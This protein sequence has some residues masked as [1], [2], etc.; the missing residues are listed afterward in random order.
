MYFP[1]THWSLLAKATLD[2]EAAGCAALEELCRRYWSPL[3]HFIR[4][5]GYGEAEAEDLTQ[6][7]LVYLMTESA[8][9]RPDPTRGR[10]RSFLLGTLNNFLSHERERR[11]AQKRGGGW[12]HLSV[13]NMA[14]SDEASAVD[15]NGLVAEFD[16]VWAQT[17]V[18]L[19][20]QAVEEEYTKADKSALFKILR[21]FLPGGMAPPSYE[22]AVAR[23]GVSVAA[24]TSEV[25]RLRRRFRECVYAE[26]T[27]TVSA[28]H[29]TEEEILHLYRVL[30]DRGTD[31]RPAQKS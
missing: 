31:L 11:F 15:G 30:M 22:E 26:V 8:L 6:E 4:A 20:L 9:R 27:S 17:I 25:H 13:E 16:R 2:G 10:F 23:T 18:R 7:F 29:E 24:F 28:P 3:N 5:R 21:L 12:A 14:P 1:T 19:A